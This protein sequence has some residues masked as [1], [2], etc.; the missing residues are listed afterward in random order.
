MQ[1]IL[2]SYLRRLTNLTATNRSLMLLRLVSEQFIDLHDLNFTQNRS[3]F[4]II[5]ELIGRKQV[6][7]LCPLLDARDEMTNAMSR[8]LKRLNRVEKF[9]F[10]E[11]GSKDLYV[12]WPFLRGKFAD[13]TLVRCPLM[14]FPVELESR[15]NLWMLKQREEVNITLNKT[16]LLAYAYFNKVKIGDDLLE[17]VFDDFDTDSTVF[18][19]ALYQLFKESPVEIN[20]NPDNFTNKLDSFESFTKKDFDAATQNGV[21]KLMP[22]AVLGMFPQAGSHLVPDYLDMIENNKV[23]DIEEFFTSR[24]MLEEDMSKMPITNFLGKVREER[25]ITPYRLDAFQENALKAVKKGNSIV[26]QGPPGTGKSQLICNLIADGIASGKK[27]LVVSQKR[28]ALDVVYSRLKE[29]GIAE[30][31]GLVHDFKNDRKEIYAKLANQI[32]RIPEY[33]SRN[34]SLDVIQLERQFQTSSRTIDKL[35]EEL[36]EYKE[37]LFTESECGLSVKELYLTSD[38]SARIINLRQVYKNFNFNDVDAFMDKL[39]EYISYSKIFSKKSYLLF[40]RKSFHRFGLQD[41]KSMQEIL[42]EIPSLE[43][44]TGKQMEKIIGEKLRIEE[45]LKLHEQKEALREFFRILKEDRVYEYFRRIIQFPEKDTNFLSISNTERVLLECF[46]GQGIESSLHA[47]E[48]GKFQKTL[49]HA[50]ESKKH[51][52]PFIKWKLFGKDKYFIKRVLVANRLS[53]DRRGFKALIEKM[54]NRLNLEHNLTK[55]REK[56]WVKDLPVD[57]KKVSFQSWFHFQKQALKAKEIFY[58]IRNFKNYFSINTL[59]YDEFLEKVEQMFAVI[60]DIFEHRNKW[61]QYFTASQIS[62]L[63]TDESLSYR[64]SEVLN[65]D[66]DALCEYDKIVSGLKSYEQ[67]VLEK[68]YDMQ[69]ELETDAEILFQN[70]LRLAWIDHIEA[71]YPILRSTASGKFLRMVRDLQQAV[72]KKYEVSE[73]I[74]LIKARERSYY[75]VKYNRLNNM[76]TYRDLL[77]QVTKKRRVWPVRRLIAAFHNELF[78]LLP[79]WMASPESVSAIFPMQ[80]LF[81][82]VIFDEASQCFAEKGIPAMYRGKQIVIAGDSKQLRPNDLYQIRWEEDETD[83]PV[84]EIDSLLELAS[85]YLMN[86]QLKGHYRSRSLDLIEFSNFHFYEGNLSMLP[87]KKIANKRQPGIEYL[88]VN[89]IW[90]NN[91]NMEEA[92]KVAD[93]V[94]D[95]Q[96]GSPDKSVGVVTFNARQQNLIMDI[97]EERMTKSGVMLSGSVFVKNIE[98]VQGDER[99]III[100]S[101]AYAEDQSGRLI[102]QFGSL[103]AVGG[104]NR[105]NVAITRAREKIYIVSS[106]YPNQLK[107]ED[108]KNEGPKLLKAYLSYALDVSKGNYKAFQKKASRHSPGWYL[109]SKISKTAID[110]IGDIEILDEMPLADLTVKKDLDYIGLI[111][112]DDDLYYQSIS[113]KETYVYTPL[114]LSEKNWNF[115]EVHSRMYWLDEKKVNENILWFINSH[116]TAT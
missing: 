72:E 110:K 57:Y 98:N 95:I 108:A 7:S 28:A 59:L 24:V 2:K 112:T 62:R 18:R 80:Q 30:F 29:K 68:L 25:I 82:I 32:T 15:N 75:E 74:L 36:E 13:R 116:T 31:T 44:E 113:V 107:V 70:S 38:R 47:S 101:T 21:I 115:T 58:S 27:V 85:P 3:S 71:K 84:L 19:T 51:L 105:L 111:L 78:D 97:L 10:E 4:E 93:I 39:R 17:R 11:R 45:C 91:T 50:I 92:L 114:T 42:E 46:R 20:F 67:E 22:E 16:F 9:I 34:N 37:A 96:T 90:E 77:H 35:T 66:F 6:I 86:V 103:N 76:V 12:G 102:M 43:Y 55:L 26:V 60:D 41:L 99:D 94:F 53:N 104:E 56:K 23:A 100:F 64:I 14:F 61:L 5:E 88:K 106:I 1:K 73:D 89:G 63:I 33:Q 8:K 69:E 81:D 40:D 83:D 49:E 87:D 109:K 65:R 48:L 79:C 52:I 54:D